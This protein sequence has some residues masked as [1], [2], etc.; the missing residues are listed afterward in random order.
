MPELRCEHDFLPNQCST[1]KPPPFGLNANVFVTKNSQAFHNE[2]SCSFLES[3]QNFAEKRGG[4]KQQHLIRRWDEVITSLGACEWCCALFLSENQ[5]PKI[6]CLAYISNN[7]ISVRFL[8][9]RF[10]DS[11]YKEF[12]V[13]HEESRKIYFLTSDKIEFI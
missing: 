12:Q 7:W 1:C 10:V 2:S 8:R 5:N 11:R 13:Y 4:T 9:D 3:G 6:N